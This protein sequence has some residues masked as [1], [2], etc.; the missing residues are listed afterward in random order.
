MTNWMFPPEFYRP[1]ITVDLIVS[2]ALQL[3]RRK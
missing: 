2:R 1:L 3:R